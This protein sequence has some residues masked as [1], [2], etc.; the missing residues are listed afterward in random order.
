MYHKLT[1]EKFL[2][3]ESSDEKLTRGI[4]SVEKHS[5]GI[6]ADE[7]HTEGVSA[8]ENLVNELCTILSGLDDSQEQLEKDAFDV[9]NSSDT[10]LN[11]VKESIGSVEEILNIIVELNRAV[12]MSTEKINQLEKLSTQIEQFASVIDSI[13]NRT[14]ILSLNASIEAARAGEHGRGFAVVATEVRDLASQSSKS[15]KEITST[16]G[17]VQDAVKE[18]VNSMK[19]IFENA[20]QQKQKAGNVDGLLKQV[21]AAAYAAN[22]VARN[23]ENEIAYQRDITEEVKNVLRKSVHSNNVCSKSK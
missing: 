12:E 17:Q 9:I 5:G 2:D 14:N 23:I 4:S 20:S 15:S 1:D 8:D 6:S 13:A 21:I 18:T 11:L 7:K 19:T 3:V 16:I 22:E 10:S